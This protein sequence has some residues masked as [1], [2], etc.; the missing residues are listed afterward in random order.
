MKLAEIQTKARFDVPLE[1]IWLL[2][3][4]G[5]TFEFPPGSFKFSQSERRAR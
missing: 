3:V 2:G 4:G 1:S 5:E